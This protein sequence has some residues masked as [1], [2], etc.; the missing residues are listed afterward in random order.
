MISGLDL[1]LNSRVSCFRV[2]LSDGG[3]SIQLDISTQERNW[4]WN[5]RGVRLI[6][7]PAWIFLCYVHGLPSIHYKSSANRYRKIGRLHTWLLAFDQ[8]RVASCTGPAI[9]VRSKFHSSS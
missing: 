6:R 3:H 8:A 2:T 1:E 7:M 9:H 5:L 4:G